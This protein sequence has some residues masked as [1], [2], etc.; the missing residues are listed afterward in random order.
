M[1]FRPETP[2]DNIESAQ[3]FV[4]LLIEAIEESRR[5]MDADIA[6]SESN[7]SERQKQTLRLV[8]NNLCFVIIP[9]LF[10]KA[11]FNYSAIQGVEFGAIICLI[12]WIS[13]PISLGLLNKKILSTSKT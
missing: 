13:G 2:F 12:A 11:L 8:S 3:Q 1:R 7:R 9:G 5:N 10:F 4:E 6:L